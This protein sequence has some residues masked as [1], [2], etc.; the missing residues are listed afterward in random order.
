MEDTTTRILEFL[1]YFHTWE[2]D[3]TFQL[4]CNFI[5]Q[6]KY[7]V[8]L[9]SKEKIDKLLNFYKENKQYIGKQ[10]CGQI[11]KNNIVENKNIGLIEKI[12]PFK[13]IDG[14]KRCLAHNREYVL[15]NSESCALI[16]KNLMKVTDTINCVIINGILNIIFENNVLKFR[17]DNLIINKNKIILDEINIKNEL[18]KNTKQELKN[19]T[20]EEKNKNKNN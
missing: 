19:K 12:Y 2:N 18:V 11:L 17:T 5:N 4:K 16:C 7:E 6:K 13:N 8:V 1:K 14:L 3:F 10:E 15:I 20:I 9:V